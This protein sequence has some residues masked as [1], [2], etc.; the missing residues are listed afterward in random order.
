MLAGETGYRLI[1]DGQET[2]YLFFKP[3]SRLAVPGRVEQDLS[4]SVGL[5]FPEDDIFGE[6]KKLLH[7]VILVS[8]M[9][10]LLLFVLC[11]T[12]THRQLLPLRMLANSAQRIAE[13]HYDEPIPDSSQ[14][15]EIGQLQ[16]H[17]QQMQQSLAAKVGE[18]HELTESLQ[19]RGKVLSQAYEQ[20]KEADRIKTAFLHRMSNH[21]IAPANSIHTSVMRLLECGQQLE[22]EEGNR[23]AEEILRQGATTATLLKNLLDEAE[24]KQPNKPV[25][26]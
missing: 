4:W 12:I 16:S 23:L 2:G 21:M 7:V 5:F 6:Y 22:Q 18:L 20:A 9:G 13:G 10:L 15:D 1:K 11:R 24:I 19:E 25:E 3:F 8:V 14:Q 26:P 17:F